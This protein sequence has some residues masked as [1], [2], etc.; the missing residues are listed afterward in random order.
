MSSISRVREAIC[1]SVPSSEVEVE[2]L[3]GTGD[4]FSVKVMSSTF[5]GLSKLKQH[6]LVYE[7][8]KS[9]L[10][11]HSIHAITL[12]TFIPK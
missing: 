10:Q 3:T 11:N 8:L 1:L 6:K 2:D 12:S 9:E 4:H 7:A 5:V